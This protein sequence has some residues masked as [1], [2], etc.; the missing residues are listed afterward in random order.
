[1][2][3]TAVQQ[4]TCNLEEKGSVAGSTP[5]N[6]PKW[7]LHLKKWWWVY[8]LGLSCGILII[9]LPVIYVAVPRIA[10][11]RMNKY[12]LGFDTLSITNPTPT[13][14][15]VRLSQTSH[16]G[17][18]SGYLSGFNATISA[19][20]SDTPF[21]VFPFPRTDFGKTIHLELDQ[22]ITLSCVSC[23]SELA[24]EALRSNEVAVQVSGNPDLKIQGLPKYHLDIDKIVTLPAFMDG[25][26]EFRI[27]KL[28]L[29]DPST[30]NGYNMNASIAVKAPSTF[31]VELG[32][33]GLNLTLGDSPLGYI[34]VPNLTFSNGACNAVILGHFDSGLLTQAL[35]G[36]KGSDHGMVTIGIHGNRSVHNGEEIPYFTAAL[37]SF[38]VYRKINLLDFAPKA[39]GG[40]LDSLLGGA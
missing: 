30:H 40:R 19:G 23:F 10:N 17:L 31:D 7:K 37:Q 18:R 21:S 3:K 28:D 11:D 34:D 12:K 9:V 5:S 25:D 36:S 20:S 2:S 24:K 6:P 29:V 13:S 15:H 32:T 8:L 33:V 1:M 14:V 26:N 27:I 39:L 22:D 16:T 38:S 4:T 35:F